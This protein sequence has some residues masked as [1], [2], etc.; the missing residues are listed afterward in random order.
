MCFCR[1]IKVICF[2]CEWFALTVSDLL[3][4]WVNLISPWVICFCRDSCGPVVGYP[5]PGS[6]NYSPNPIHYKTF[7][8][9]KTISSRWSQCKKRIGGIV[10]ETATNA[11]L[12]V[13][14][15]R[16]EFLGDVT[17]PRPRALNARSW[18][19]FYALW[20]RVEKERFAQNYFF[21]RSTQKNNY[22]NIK[23]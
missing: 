6:H 17:R 4:T 18:N 8:R 16:D 12:N 3:F 20:R 13:L 22:K 10:V 1:F 7:F 15:P 5:I 9:L 23:I 11:S 21:R 19:N 2:C 14:R